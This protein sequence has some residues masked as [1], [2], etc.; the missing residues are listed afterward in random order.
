MP[1]VNRFAETP[2]VTLLR[3][4]AAFEPDGAGVISLYLDLRAGEHGRD[5]HL[6]FFRRAAA[7]LRE[8]SPPGAG[9]PAG[10]ALALERIERFLATDVGPSANGAAIFTTLGDGDFFEGL[11]IDAPFEAHQIFVGHVPHLYPL[12]RVIDQYPRY[13]AL[14]LDSNRARI[15]VFALGEVEART[16][17]TGEKTRRHSMG[18]WSQARYQRR[19]DNIQLLHL[20]DVVDALETVVRDEAI[21][22][23]IV[24]GDAVIVARLREQ[25]PAALAGKVM[26]VLR[27][28]R[29]AGEDD[30]IDEALAALRRKDAEGDAQRVAEVLDAWRAGGLGVAGPE[31]TLNALQLGQ[32]DELL[33]VAA[34]AALKPVQRLSADAAAAPSMTESPTGDGAQQTQVHLADTLVTK[35][36]QTGAA[37]RIIEDPELLRDH[38]GVAAALR[39][40]I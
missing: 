38:G 11:A 33:V 16:E 22:R 5:T 28:D 18:G 1:N 20:K 4:L 13:A 35:A 25:L 3:T 2:P 12:V 17:V 26:D 21:D 15:I 39:F 10:T 37:V 24:A 36:T 30:I 8:V 19:I 32:V 27:L 31:A 34:P 7:E 14:L 9:A 29:H 6:G 40:R 23:I